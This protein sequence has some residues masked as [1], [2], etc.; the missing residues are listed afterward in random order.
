MAKAPA[1]K[2]AEKGMREQ[3]YFEKAN[4]KI[5]LPYGKGKIAF[6][7][8]KGWAADILRSN[9][10]SPALDPSQEVHQSFENPL[11]GRRLEDFRG[12]K[13]VAIAVSDETRFIPYPM[14]LSPLLERLE[15]I[16]VARSAIQIL[17]ASGLHPPVS[18]SRFSHILPMEILKRYSVMAHDATHPALK[19]L[20]NTSRGTPVF[21][22]PHFDEAQLRI[23]IGLIDPHQFVGY[24]GGVKGAAIGLAG[25]QTIEANHSMLFHPQAVIGEIQ[26][27]PVRQDIEEIGK[28]IGIHFVVNVVLDE[29]NQIIKVFSGDPQEVERVGSEF[30]RT[31]YEAKVSG[32][33][34]V[35]IVS[36]GGYPKDINVYQAQKAL[37]HATP[38]V[39]QGGDILLFAECPDGHGDEAFY[40]MMRQYKKPDEVIE[41]FQ[42]GRF[43][44][45][46]HK[47]FLW[48][49]SLT[50]AQVQMCSALGERLS[51]ELMTSPAK[52]VEQALQRLQKKYSHP[53]RIAVMPK[54][55]STYVKVVRPF[56]PKT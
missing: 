1:Q 46:T 43:K 28:L 44:M 54:A 33:Y 25:S 45:G 7:L 20:G 19:F 40:Q 6:D 16:G 29:G 35:A 31:I 22:N 30:C 56:Y 15:R 38:L 2:V 47:A 49:R 39:R 26:Q 41:A 4:R 48:C 21:L 11:G 10:A 18:Q 24:T 13:S 42:K 50:K 37:A 14:I 34:D 53:P 55:N 27:N 52:S 32:E 12:A 23:I 9:L 17:I 36:P 51:W 3:G 5:E 8:P